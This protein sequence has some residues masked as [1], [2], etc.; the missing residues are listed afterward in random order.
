MQEV[1]KKREEEIDSKMNVTFDL[2]KGTTD[3][4]MN[5]V[6]SM[7]T[8]GAQNKMVNEFL[9][10]KQG[11]ER[12]QGKNGSSSVYKPGQSFRPYEGDSS[13]GKNGMDSLGSLESF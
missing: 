3:L 8:F 11:G 1:E 7:F 4:K 2:V 10:T 9:G 6:D 12:D 13:V 5:E